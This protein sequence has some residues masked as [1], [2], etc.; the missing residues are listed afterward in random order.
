M[1]RDILLE[2]F[3]RCYKECLLRH[4]INGNESSFFSIPDIVK[5]LTFKDAVFWCAEASDETTVNVPER[6]GIS[7]WREV[8]LH[9]Y[10]YKALQE[11]L[12]YQPLKLLLKV[13]KKQ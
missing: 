8:L 13:H 2:R 5:K 12:L 7:F 9:Q 11:V 3:K 10:R 6:V 1:D 4:L